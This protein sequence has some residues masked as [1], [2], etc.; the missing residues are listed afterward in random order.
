MTTPR[1]IGT[2]GSE[3]RA[4]LLDVTE[5]LMRDEGYAAVS[6]RRVASEAGVTP[7]LIHYYFPTLD[8]LF[9]AL[10]RRGAEKNLARHARA[11]ESPQPLR[12]LWKF[13]IEPAGTAVLTEFMALA[14]HRKSIR[15]EIAEYAERFRRQQADL[16]AGRLQDYGIDA[17]DVPPPAVLVLMST[18]ARGIVLEDTLGITTGHVETLDLVERLLR[19]F[20]GP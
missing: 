6:S 20:E 17:E 12:A 14:N 9:L 11:L 13:N 16:L 8:D 1:R 2:E 4:L 19:R 3:T 5:R 10:F 15:A 7:A 18:V